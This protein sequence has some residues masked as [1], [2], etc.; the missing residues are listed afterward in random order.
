MI[1]DVALCLICIS[2]SG[3]TPVGTESSSRGN[4]VVEGTVGTG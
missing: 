3:E 2:V 4:R 1:T